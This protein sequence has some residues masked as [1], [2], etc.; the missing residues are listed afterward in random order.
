MENL[1]L[2]LCLSAAIFYSI[3]MVSQERKLPKITPIVVTFLFGLGVMLYGLPIV[4]AEVVMGTVKWPNNWEWCLL[5]IIPIIAFFADWS[6]F[7]AIH[8]QIGSIALATMYMAIPVF[9]SLLKLESPS[10][11]RVISWLLTGL[12]LFTLVR[13]KLFDEGEDATGDAEGHKKRAAILGVTLAILATFLYSAE[14][15]VQDVFL[16]HISSTLLATAGGLA[17]CAYSGIVILLS[18]PKRKLRFPEGKEWAWAFMIP[19]MSFAADCAHFG[20]LHVK[21]GS[22]TLAMFYVTCPVWATFVSWRKPTKWH[23]WAWIFAAAGLLLLI[24]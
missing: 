9:A 16:S 18:G 2:I 12:A 7:V 4:T 11:P 13:G 23:I 5:F 19:I 14:I 22:V 17:T 24:L 20:A 8:A 15:V 6:H 1:G 10:L 21:A 3:E